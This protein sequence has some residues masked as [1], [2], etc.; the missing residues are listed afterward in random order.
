MGKKINEIEFIPLSEE[1]KSEDLIT[2]KESV[3]LWILLAL[4]VL[5]SFLAPEFL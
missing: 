1:K 5:F 4:L 2:V 3:W